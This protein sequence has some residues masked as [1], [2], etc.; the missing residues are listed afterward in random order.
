MGEEKHQR[1]ILTGLLLGILMA[2][3][4]IRLSRLRL[5]RF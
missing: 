1:F 5:G 2:A 3:M 4:L